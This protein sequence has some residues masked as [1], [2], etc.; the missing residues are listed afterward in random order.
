[1]AEIKK[2]PPFHGRVFVILIFIYSNF[3]N[4]HP[5]LLKTKKEKIK[6]IKI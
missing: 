2:D 1:M 4:A 3:N 6:T 5:A